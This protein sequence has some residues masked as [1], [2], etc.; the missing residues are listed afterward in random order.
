MVFGKISI[1]DN[2]EEKI[3]T[4]KILT[5][6]YAPNCNDEII[7]QT[8]NAEKKFLC[9]LKLIPQHITGKQAKKLK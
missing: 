3:R 2:E 5:K 9:M 7:N 6:K 1:I 8:I 4:I